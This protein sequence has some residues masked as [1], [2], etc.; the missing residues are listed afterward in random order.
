MISCIFLFDFTVCMQ[1]LYNH[2]GVT[3]NFPAILCK[4]F[5]IALILGYFTNFDT[6]LQKTRLWKNLW[7][8]CIT[9]RIERLLWRYAN[10]IQKLYTP[11][12]QLFA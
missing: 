5:L 8:V 1:K 2:S 12:I 3:K 9:F 6:E 11:K 10:C 4:M 7:N